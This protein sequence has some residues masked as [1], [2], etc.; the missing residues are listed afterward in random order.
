MTDKEIIYNH[1]DKYFKANIKI[2]SEDIYESLM[3]VQFI[4]DKKYLSEQALV[5]EMISTYGIEFIDEGEYMSCVIN[6]WLRSK[7][8]NTFKDILDSLKQVKIV[9][10]VRSWEV[11]RHD[12][13][14]DLDWL[15]KKHK[16]TYAKD[17]IIAV[18]NDW[19]HKEIIKIS[20]EILNN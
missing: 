18:Y 19:K 15:I 13:D 5:K 2:N 7:L 11:K 20:D 9:F 12:L 14:F 6:D 10:G 3:N 8:N 17:T 1:L 4:N 16:G